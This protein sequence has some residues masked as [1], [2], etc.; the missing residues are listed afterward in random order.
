MQSR[1]SDSPAY[2]LISKVLTVTALIAVSPFCAIACVP[3]LCFLIPV[4][5]MAMPFM[6]V[7]FFGETRE[8]APAQPLRVLQPAR[9]AA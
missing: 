4:A 8:I 5:F 6:V 3:L 1:K 9:L 7:A 2:T